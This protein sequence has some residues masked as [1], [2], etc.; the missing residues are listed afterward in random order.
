M[1]SVVK[2]AVETT[3]KAAAMKSAVETAM[4]GIAA[5]ARLA[6][7]RSVRAKRISDLPPRV[8]AAIIRL[9]RTNYP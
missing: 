9:D 7:K 4:A 8:S 2:S 5:I 3:M 6:A 1:E